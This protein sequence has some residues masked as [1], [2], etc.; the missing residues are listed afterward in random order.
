MKKLAAII[1]SGVLAISLTACGSEMKMDNYS[2]EEEAAYYQ[3][4]TG[5]EVSCELAVSMHPSSQC[6]AMTVPTFKMTL[7]DEWYKD[8]AAEDVTLS[9]YK[10][11]TVN[12][13]YGTDTLLTLTFSGSTDNLSNGFNTDTLKGYLDRYFKSGD[14]RKLIKFIKKDVNEDIERKENKTTIE[15]KVGGAELLLERES[16][17]WTMTINSYY[18]NDISDGGLYI[19]KA[20]AA[21]KEP[22]LSSD[23]IKTFIGD[24]NV[25]FDYKTVVDIDE[26]MTAMEYFDCTL[27]NEKYQHDES[28]TATANDS[29]TFE[30]YY[31][32]VAFKPADG[33]KN[34]LVQQSCIL[35]KTDN[36]VTYKLNALGDSLSENA[37]VNITA[38]LS[39]INPNDIRTM[40]SKR[41]TEVSVADNA[42]ATIDKDGNLSLTVTIASTEAAQQ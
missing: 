23:Y 38:G 32:S 22:L 33:G 13:T 5:N 2:V 40:L 14:M 4:L 27:A 34:L 16:D 25:I 17:I 15:Y 12:D 41:D 20:L 19:D 35:N 3:G 18:N 29:S 21:E 42:K 11:M 6:G 24:T 36:T 9:V 7:N 28:V 39:N 31:S 30:T 26:L 1:M 8:T 10:L 37:L